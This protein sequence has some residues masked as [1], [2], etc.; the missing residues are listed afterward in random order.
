MTVPIFLGLLAAFGVLTSYITEAVKKTLK[1]KTYSAN[2]IVLAVSL[3]IGSG[4]TAVFYII[5]HMAF[6][7]TNILCM[8]LMAVAVWLVAM[9]GYD[10]VMQLIAQLSKIGKG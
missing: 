1:R 8:I 9:L 7:T 2:L 5:K 4:G 10:K 3:V 6:N